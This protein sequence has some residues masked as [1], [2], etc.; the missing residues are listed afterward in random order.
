MGETQTRT[1]VSLAE[2]A[3]DKAPQCHIVSDD[4]A[5]PCTHIEGTLAR[6]NKKLSSGEIT[7]EQA[8][9]IIHTEVDER[10]KGIGNIACGGS[11]CNFGINDRP[12]DLY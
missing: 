1:I 2:L 8:T 11:A 6:A 5:V 3:Y 9:E 12:I 4:E 10:C 7:Y